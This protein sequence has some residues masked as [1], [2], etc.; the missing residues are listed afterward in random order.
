MKLLWIKKLYSEH[1]GFTQFEKVKKCYFVPRSVLHFYLAYLSFSSGNL[2]VRFWKR[3]PRGS[4]TEK[5][6]PRRP[7]FHIFTLLNKRVNRPFV[8]PGG[9]FANDFHI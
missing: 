6:V 1:G 3:E 7:L 4:G 9:D 5:T 2:N 8:P